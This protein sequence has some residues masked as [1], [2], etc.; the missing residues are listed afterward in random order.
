MGLSSSKLRDDHCQRGDQRLEKVEES[1]GQSEVDSLLSSSSL[2]WQRRR[3]I[4]LR[5]HRRASLERSYL[6]AG[7]YELQW[8]WLGRTK[9]F[10]LERSSQSSTDVHTAVFLSFRA[11]TA[12]DA[13]DLPHRD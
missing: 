8:P 9:I 10:L 11:T 6:A 7:G 3:C 2:Q 1:F 5:T 4:S 12:T 13:L